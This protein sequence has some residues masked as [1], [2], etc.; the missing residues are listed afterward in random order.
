MRFSDTSIA[1]VKLIEP[2]RHEDPRGFFT[3]LY[4]ETLFRDGGIDS[5]F[6]QESLS[7]SKGAWTVRG[8]HFQVPPRPQSKVI[9]VTRGAIFDVV[10]DLRHGSPTYGKHLVK[11]LSAASGHMLF[12]DAG[13]AHGFCTLL[14]D[15]EVIYRMSDYWSPEHERGLLWCDPALAIEWPIKVPDAIVSLRD[16]AHPTLAGLPAYFTTAEAR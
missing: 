16:S 4:R 12:I 9:Q 11:E 10:V 3:E 7:L 13:C 14:A 5:R 15:T 2:T 8:L 6:V 1:G